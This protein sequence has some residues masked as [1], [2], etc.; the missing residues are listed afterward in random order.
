[1]S[2]PAEYGLDLSEENAGVMKS[3]GF[4]VVL[5]SRYTFENGLYLGIDGNFSYSTNEMVEVFETA[6]TRDNPNRSRTG[7]AYGTPFGYKSLGLFSTSDDINNDGIIN[8]EDGYNV[9]QFGDL[10][11]GDIR[12][13]DVSGPEGVPDGK[14]DANDEVVIGNPAYPGITYGLTTNASWKG[15]D[16]SLFFQG[17]AMASFDLNQ[18]F[19]TLPFANNSSNTTTEYYNNRWTPSSENAKY[20][21]ATQSPYANNT[22]TSDFWMVDSKFVRL[23]TAQ[24][25]YTFPTSLTEALN[26]QSVRF[27][28]TGQNLFTISKLDFIDPEAGF[29]NQDGGDIDRETAYPNSKVVTFGFDL[30][31]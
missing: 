19:H 12:Y 5:G 3:H 20:P 8:S 23:K 26:I 22:Q 31:F 7:R 25:G 4:E 17:S 27:Y 24:L 11:P 15:F 13:A 18:S 1:V 30:N 29:T 9:T 10:H 16:A 28:V 2:V 6:A 21:R 14:I